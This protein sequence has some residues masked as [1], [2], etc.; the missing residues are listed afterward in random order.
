MIIYE[1]YSANDGTTLKFVGT[2]AEAKK[3]QRWWA[4]K[5]YIVE[6]RKLVAHTNAEWLRLLNG[7]GASA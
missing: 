3:E 6:Y 5:E 4:G 1:C 7:Y 2:K